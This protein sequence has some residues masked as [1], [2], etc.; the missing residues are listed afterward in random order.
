MELSTTTYAIAIECRW[1]KLLSTSWGR[2]MW[3]KMLKQ[4]IISARVALA[5]PLSNSRF[6]TP[7][8]K[9]V[10]SIL[11]NIES[12]RTSAVYFPVIL[13]PKLCFYRLG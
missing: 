8:D 6:D 10:F 9:Y 3:G 7:D 13:P 11:H 1:Q 12:K 5:T 2:P 4:T